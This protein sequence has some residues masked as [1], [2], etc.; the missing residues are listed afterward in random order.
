MIRQDGERA[1]AEQRPIVTGTRQQGMVE[2][3]DGVQPGERIVADGLNKIQPGQ[4]IR[5]GGP[6]PTAEGARTPA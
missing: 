4:P 3:R 2:I 1:V 5:V 6:R